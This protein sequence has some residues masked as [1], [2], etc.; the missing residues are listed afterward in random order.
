MIAAVTTLSQF[1]L[2]EERM[3]TNYVVD[4]SESDTWLAMGAM[5]LADGLVSPRE[6][7]TSSI[8]FH[9]LCNC[10]FEL[11]VASFSGAFRIIHHLN[12]WVHLCPFQ[13]SP[14]FVLET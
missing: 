6:D 1:I 5:S 9:Q 8:L 2:L 3:T 10:A 13:E 12:I 11:Q 14:L 7:A 4:Q